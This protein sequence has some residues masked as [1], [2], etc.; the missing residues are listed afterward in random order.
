MSSYEDIFKSNRWLEQYIV[1][2]EYSQGRSAFDFRP[3]MNHVSLLYEYE[4]EG[5]SDILRCVL[6]LKLKLKP[7]PGGMNC[8]ILL[9]LYSCSIIFQYPE[10]LFIQQYFHDYLL[11]ISFFR[12]MKFIRRKEDL[13]EINDFIIN[14]YYYYY[15]HQ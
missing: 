7:K 11:L 1:V 9:Y 4:Y 6:K 13:D 2:Q 14:Y 8:N 12:D 10:L 3:G 15:H 5:C